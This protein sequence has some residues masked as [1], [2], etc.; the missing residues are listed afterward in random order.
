M[1]TRTSAPAVTQCLDAEWA[2]DA[3]LATVNAQRP[4]GQ[5]AADWRAYSEALKRYTDLARVVAAEGLQE[6][7]RSARIDRINATTR[8]VA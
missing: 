2:M 5:F 4:L 3:A 8:V 6:A 7:Y 1:D